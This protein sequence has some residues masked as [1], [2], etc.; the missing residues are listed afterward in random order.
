MLRQ[1]VLAGKAFDC[2]EMK[3]SHERNPPVFRTAE[4]HQHHPVSSGQADHPLARFG[5][6]K[7]FRPADKPVE[8]L[9]QF[10]L[11]V[12]RRFE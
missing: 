3:P 12:N 9:H 5:V 6:A 1:T 2:P 8:R 4:E 10:D 11:L 7:T